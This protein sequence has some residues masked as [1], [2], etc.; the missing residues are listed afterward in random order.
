MINVCR[1]DSESN[2][3]NLRAFSL[4][5]P[6][7]SHMASLLPQTYDTS[8]EPDSE[9]DASSESSGSSS[10]GSSSSSS[11]SSANSAKEFLKRQSQTAKARAASLLSRGKKQLAR[12]AV[13]KPP[14]HP[15]ESFKDDL[16]GSSAINQAGQYGK[17]V[18]FRRLRLLVSYVKAWCS[19]VVL[20][21]QRL[22][23]KI[24]HTIVTAIVDDTNV[25]LSEVPAGCSTW[26][27]SRVVT[28]MNTV[29]KLV[30]SHWEATTA[31]Q[32]MKIFNVITPLVV[33]PKADTKTLTAQLVLQLFSFLGMVSMRY[34]DLVPE[35][36]FSDVQIQGTILSLDSLKANVSMLK[37]FRA[38]VNSHCKK[39]ECRDTQIHPLLGILCMLHQLALARTPILLGFR[40]FWSSV[41][42][43]AHLFE[44]HSF[45]RQFRL[46][47]LRVLCDNFTYVPVS[48]MPQ[49]FAQW[50]EGRNRTF[51]LTSEGGKKRWQLHT[52]LMKWDNGSMDSAEFTHYCVGSCCKGDS[53]AAKHWFALL[54]LSKYYVLLFTFGYPVP[55]T[56][57]WT[58][59]QRA[60][61]YVKEP[62]LMQIESRFAVVVFKMQF[63]SKQTGWQVLV[64]RSNNVLLF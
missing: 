50:R 52:Q 18:R 24:D 35:R 6:T 46:A 11:S 51:R 40:G 25:R 2:L 53:Q 57:R 45:R 29:Q 48:E 31:S 63:I 28:V 17:T 47:L 12:H 10:P 60:I 1:I 16:E 7:V 9:D 36:L 3:W 41:V 5:F 49:G 61:Q 26:R 37:H 43:L 13:L 19:A 20:F 15:A 14:A 38:A 44:N 59:A 64:Q 33:L 34:K 4:A 32:E 8:S 30:V 22:F 55:L 42:R 62:G 39:S 21:C 54:Q 56:Y 23:G 27:M 58:H